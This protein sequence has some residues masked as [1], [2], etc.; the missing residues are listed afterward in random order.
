[1][2][3]VGMPDTPV[4]IACAQAQPVAGDVVANVRLAAAMVRE[5]GDAGATIVQFP[6]KFLSGYEPDL[7]RSDPDKYAVTAEDPRLQPIFEA[8]WE[9]EVAAVIGAAARDGGDLHVS[10]LIVDGTGG[11]RGFYHKQFLFPTERSLYAAGRTGVALDLGNWRFGLA[12]CYDTGF[13][14]HARAA[15]L[16]GCHVYFASAL[17]SAGNGYYESRVWFPA[18]ALDNTMF[19][20]LS[21]HVGTT[22]DW[23]TCGASAIWSPYGNVLAE[24]GRDNRQLVIATLEPEMLRKM[25]EQETMLS[26]LPARLRMSGTPYHV[27]GLVADAIR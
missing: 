13:P 25:R 10:S 21:N 8:C 3:A 2:D 16:N 26:D 27:I 11:F 18:R 7:I 9:N 12:I 23:Q 20:A 6:E 14:E 17:F 5:A 4:T 19:C 24:A 22:G 15:A 1:M